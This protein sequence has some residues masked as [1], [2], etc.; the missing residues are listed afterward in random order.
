MVSYAVVSPLIDNPFTLWEVN[1]MRSPLLSLSVSILLAIA[2]IS[3]PTPTNHDQHKSLMDIH[4]VPE[5]SLDISNHNAVTSM[6]PLDGANR[7]LRRKKEM[8]KPSNQPSPAL[9]QRH[10]HITDHFRLHSGGSSLAKRSLTGDLIVMGF[11]LIWVQ[12]DVI[13]SSSLAYYRTTEFYKNMTI[14]AGGE[15]S[16]G[17][18]VQN[19][20]ITYGV[21]RLTFSIM[22]EAVAGA[23]QDIAREFPNGFGPFLY[24][25]A[26]VMVALTAFVLVATYQMLAFSLHASIWITMVI[27]QNARVPDMVTGP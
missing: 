12:A 18:T 7:H 4:N 23:A 8:F 10:D 17:P 2:S 20:M 6:T 27:V 26:E 14:L 21:F 11:K 19:Y 25:F 1:S 24:D 9:I 22:A 13:V 5:Q 3:F 16:F 15:F